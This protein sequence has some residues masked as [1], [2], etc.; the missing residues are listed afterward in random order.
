MSGTTMETVKEKFGDG[1]YVVIETP[2]GEIVGEL[3]F[4]K[5]PLTV[6]N[7]VGLAEGSLTFAK[8]RAGRPYYDGIVFH[9]VIAD[10]MI[11]AGCPEARGTGGPGYEFPDEF[12]SSL[13]HSGPGI[14][15]MANRGPGTNGSQFFI[16]HRATPHLDGKHAVFGRVVSGQNV[17]DAIEQGDE[18][19]KMTV[20]RIGVAAEN[21]VADDAAWH[22][23]RQKVT[24]ARR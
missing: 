4:G 13:R 18:I 8:T 23:Y 16:T 3:F 12:D 9:R 6:A 7:F 21:F 24:G 10:F 17:V 1:L 14:F 15:S 19:K 20:L 2:K 11:Q 22:E 5:V